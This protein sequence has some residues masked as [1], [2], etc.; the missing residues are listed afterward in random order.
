MPM[1]DSTY[2]DKQLVHRRVRELLRLVPGVPS[3]PIQFTCKGIKSG[4]ANNRRGL[5]FNPIL[6]RENRE[7]FIE[8][9]VAHELAH[10]V[11][12]KRWVEQWDHN[13]GRWT[14]PRAHGRQWAAVMRTFGVPA[15]R[16]HSYDTTNARV[17]RVQ[18]GFKYSCKCRTADFTIVRH[19]KVRRGQTYTCTLCNTKLVY[20]GRD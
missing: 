16:C 11:V 19:N 7:R 15:D 2:T 8:R 10:W 20:V 14:G 5:N 13:K 1:P 9:T 12:Y 4:T 3:P 17:R 6:L 18:R